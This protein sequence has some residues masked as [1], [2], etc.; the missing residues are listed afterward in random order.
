MT[1]TCANVIPAWGWLESTGLA[2]Q[3]RSWQT[4]ARVNFK[5]IAFYASGLLNNCIHYL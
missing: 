4:L 1:G 3:W 2:L 5:I